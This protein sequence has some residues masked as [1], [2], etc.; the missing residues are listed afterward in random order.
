MDASRLR[1]CL[2]LCDPK[3]CSPP[4][5]CPWDSPGKNT[6]V[7][8]HAL[9]Q[10]I[11]L[12]QG[13]NPH[14]LCFLHWRVGSLPRT[15]PGKHKNTIPSPRGGKN[16]TQRPSHCDNFGSWEH[17]VLSPLSSLS[18]TEGMFAHL[19]THGLN[20]T[21]FSMLGWLSVLDTHC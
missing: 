1:S 20:L 8:C 7:G 6:G 13:S 14:L 4:G 17:R 11:F 9:L 19:P 16:R 12:T 2:T 15:P 21:Y 18:W 3:D 10:G 5:S